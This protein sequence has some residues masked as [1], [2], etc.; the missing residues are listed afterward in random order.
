MKPRMVHPPLN[1]DVWDQVWAGRQT[2]S[3]HDDLLRDQAELVEAVG[4]RLL[5][6]DDLVGHR[7]DR[8]R[9]AVRRDGL[10][11]ERHAGHR[12]ERACDLRAI[13]LGPARSLG[14]AIDHV[15]RLPHIRV[16][17]IAIGEIERVG[18]G[19]FIGVDQDAPVLALFADRKIRIPDRPCLDAAVGERRPRIGRRQID[20][21]DVL[22]GQ[23]G[24][25]QRG[26]QHVVGAGA[27][28]RI[29]R[30]CLSD[31]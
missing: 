18:L 21:R 26:N 25:L 14:E 12:G 17:E 31:P 19:D 6:G 28:W 23:S 8:E 1:V 5:G 2:M 7:A 22:I 9:S 29:R 3:L 24:F 13:G 11:L 30:A 16:R 20:R 15:A 10:N 27:L 4:N